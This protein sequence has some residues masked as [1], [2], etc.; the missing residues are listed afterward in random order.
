MKIPIINQKE[1][2]TIN[3]DKSKIPCFGISFEN[4]TIER[5]NSDKPIIR[6][7]DERGP[8]ENFLKENDLVLEINKKKIKDIKDFFAKQKKLNPGEVVIL[9]I[10]R[11]RQELNRAIRII[12]LDEFNNPK[13]KHSVRLGIEFNRE[14][15]KKI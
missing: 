9:R 14:E 5:K 3:K 2:N 1:I 11:N 10:K 7:I 15:Q 12:S 8:S 13:Q 4:E 6:M